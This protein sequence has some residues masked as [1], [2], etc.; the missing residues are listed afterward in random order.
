MLL[1][2]ASFSGS[3]GTCHDTP[4]VGDHSVKAPLD[5]GIAD[6]EREETAGTRHLWITGV[7]IDL[8]PWGRPSPG[9][10]SRSPIPAAR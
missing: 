7:H 8:Q 10:C 4:N 9:R 1:G 5:I 3:C 6:A 2:V